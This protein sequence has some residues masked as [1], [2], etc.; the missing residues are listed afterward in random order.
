[1]SNR[2]IL[3]PT[4]EARICLA[5]DALTVDQAKMILGWTPENDNEKFVP[6]DVHLKDGK[7]TP[8]HCS[9]ITKFQRVYTLGNLKRLMWE[10]LAGNWKLN[11]ETISVGQT[12]FV[13]D[14]KHRLAALVMA[15]QEWH[16]NPER[17]PFW[18]EE[19]TIEAVLILGLEESAEV[20]ST[21]GVGKPRSLADSIYASGLF[22]DVPKGEATKLSKYLEH[23][24]RLLWE[25]TGARED[26]Y[27]PR[28]SHAEAFDFIE[29]HPTLIHCVRT[30]F[31]EEGGKDRRLSRWLPLGY[32]AG[33]M[34]LMA[35]EGC[36][37]KAYTEAAEK[38]ESLL[39]TLVSL[40]TAESF[41]AAVA[42]K[43]KELKALFNWFEIAVCVEY[44]Y[45]LSEQMAVWLKAWNL[46][47]QG[48]SITEKAIQVKK[49]TND[50]GQTILAEDPV[51]GG[52]DLGLSFVD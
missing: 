47:F 21:I 43:D 42:N 31:L 36:D 34:Y 5:E 25:R 49:I 33:L 50:N 15:V 7:G 4:I 39:G 28:I 41:L 14:G 30:V 23:A 27:D 35:T 32:T 37:V 19:P 12:G 13:L 51:A 17:Y 45:S 11:G 46:F 9:N 8:I 3:Y 6:K 16:R 40:E 10:I 1:M 38:S 24:V 18:K 48:K 2:E 29:R 20:V 52:I 22:E 26:A 44:Q